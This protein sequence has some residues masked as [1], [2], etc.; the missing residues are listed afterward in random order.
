MFSTINGR[1]YKV[2]EVTGQV[3]GFNVELFEA[4][5]AKAGWTVKYYTGL[6]TSTAAEAKE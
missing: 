1:Q 5:A 3:T 2:D 6:G 4:I